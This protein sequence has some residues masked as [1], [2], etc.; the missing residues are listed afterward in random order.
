[1][2][3]PLNGKTLNYRIGQ[4]DRI[5]GDPTTE[6][7]GFLVYNLSTATAFQVS[8]GVWVSAVMDADLLASWYAETQANTGIGY[9]VG[10]TDRTLGAPTSAPT[11][12]LVLNTTNNTCFRA[13]GGVW[14]DGGVF[15]VA[16]LT[17]WQNA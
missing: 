8:G 5:L 13:Q 4:T 6:P 1:M 15:P 7:E 16:L 11:G 10:T 14:V 2:P 12:F 3:I 9:R 17:A